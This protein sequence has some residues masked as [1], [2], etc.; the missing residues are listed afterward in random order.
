MNALVKYTSGLDGVDVWMVILI[1]SAVIAFAVA[2]F[3]VS[4][5][6]R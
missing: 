6:Y 1:R 5:E 2:G 4:R 3:A